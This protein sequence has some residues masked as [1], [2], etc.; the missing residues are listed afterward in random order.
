MR[1]ARYQSSLWAR[2]QCVAHG[3]WDVDDERK[4]GHDDECLERTGTHQFGWISLV[5]WLTLHR[6][7]DFF[8]HFGQVPNATGGGIWQFVGPTGL[9][10]VIQN[11]H[12]LARSSRWNY[13]QGLPY[14][15]KK[16]SK[17]MVQQAYP[18]LCLH[19]QGVEWTLCHALHQGTKTQK[20]LSGHTKHYAIGR[21]KPKVIRNPF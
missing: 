8:P 16:A 6:T 13:V 5:D 15:F 20:I 17:G 4:N 9:F 11:P 14:H 1:S 7:G 21:W 3:T 2:S 19:L 12:T 18:K 10:R